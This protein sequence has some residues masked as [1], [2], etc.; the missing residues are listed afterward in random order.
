MDKR[1]Y[2]SHT[3]EVKDGFVINEQPKSLREVFDYILKK[4]PEYQV[5]IG[6]YDYFHISS[7]EHESL[8]PLDAR[9]IAVFVVQGGSEGFYVHVEAFMSNRP[10]ICLIFLGKTLQE[11]KA[12]R[13]HALKLAHAL[14]FILET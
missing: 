10:I 4:L 9:W 1:D 7:S 6:E 11:G 2:W 3:Y 12:G 13:E 5:D 14:T 8:W